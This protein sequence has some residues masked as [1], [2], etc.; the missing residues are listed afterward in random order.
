[1]EFRSTRGWWAFLE[2]EEEKRSVRWAVRLT[3][4]EYYRNWRFYKLWL[5]IGLGFAILAMSTSSRLPQESV[6]TTRRAGKTN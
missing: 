4:S 6:V 5:L 1:M 3:L 2:L